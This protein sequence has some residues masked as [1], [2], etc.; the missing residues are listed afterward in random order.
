MNC[1][2]NI[3]RILLDHGSLAALGD[4]SAAAMANSTMANSTATA[5]RNTPSPQAQPRATAEA[6]A[7][8]NQAPLQYD[9]GTP[10]YKVV[11]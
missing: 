5:T 1:V 10:N 3:L 7:A 9:G 6:D 4:R 2:F 11:L 8:L